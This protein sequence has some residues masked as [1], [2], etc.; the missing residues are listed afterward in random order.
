MIIKVYNESL[1]LI[2]WFNPPSEK[3]PH[4]DDFR[5]GPK[6]DRTPQD[7]TLHCIK[8]WERL[9]SRLR[10]DITRGFG[11]FSERFFWKE[12]YYSHAK[13]SKARL[14]ISLWPIK[15][16]HVQK[17]KD[18]FSRTVFELNNGHFFVKGFQIEDADFE[19]GNSRFNW[20]SIIIRM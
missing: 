15:Y 2:D 8:F 9:I 19:I 18:K 12:H 16:N 1:R 20:C 6:S 3:L 5:V 4:G 14:Q 7:N 11:R 10:R 17:Q 13:T